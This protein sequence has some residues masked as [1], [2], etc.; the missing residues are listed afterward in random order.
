[1][2]VAVISIVIGARETV[3][4][5]IDT[6]SGELGNKRTSGDHQNNRIVEIS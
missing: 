6:E 1:M 4:K 3:T 2:E 5:R